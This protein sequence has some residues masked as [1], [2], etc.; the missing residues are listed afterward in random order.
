MSHRVV[1]QVLPDFQLFDVAGPMAR[2]NARTAPL[3]GAGSAEA[4]GRGTN[5]CSAEM[6]GALSRLLRAAPFT[7]GRPREVRDGVPPTGTLIASGP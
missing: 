7:P 3:N 2:S 6:R 4:G 5:L 1:L